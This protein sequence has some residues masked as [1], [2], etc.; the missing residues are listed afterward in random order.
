MKALKSTYLVALILLLPMAY[1][2]QKRWALI[3][4]AKEA[5]IKKDWYVA[6]QYYHQ[7]Y[8]KDSSNKIKFGYA[9]ACRLNYDTDVAI[10]IYGKL[11]AS[12]KGNKYPLAYYWMGQL[13]KNKQKYKEAKVWFAKFLKLELKDENHAY[14]NTKAKL[15]LEA[16]DLAERLI[17]SPLNLVSD[18]PAGPV[19]TK[20]SEYAAFEKDSSL[21]FSSLRGFDP[22]GEDTT[23]VYNKIY[24]VEIRNG[25]WQKAK[26]LD[27]SFNNPRTNNANTCFSADYKQIITSRCK[28]LNA[29][30]F[31][32]ELYISNFK[33]G[34]WQP[35]VK[36]E[37]PIN[38]DGASTT[39][40]NF[41]RVDGK[42]ALFFSS[43]RAGGEG[44]MDIWY[45]M[46]KSD[47]SFETPVNAGK[48]INTPDD[49][50]SPWYINESNQ[51]YFSSTYHK[52]LG[53]FDIF[54]SSLSN[55]QFSEP[56]NAGYPINSSYNDIYYSVSKTGNKIYL[57]SNRVGSMF[58]GK[59]NCCND[60]YSFTP[61]SISTPTKVCDGPPIVKK[62]TVVALKEQMKLLVPLTL[63]FHN[64]EP[65]PRTKLTSTTKN[66]QE[67][68]EDYK[69]LL[70]QYADKFAKGL[71]GE[72]RKTAINDINTFFADSLTAGFNH[73][74]RFIDMLQKVLQN[75][76]TVRIT[77]KGY[78]SPLASSDYNINLAKR[79]VSSLRN[80]FNEVHD[81]WFVRY[82]DNNTPGEGKIIFDEMDVGELSESK[83]SDDLKDKRNSV[84]SPSAASER[85]IQV[86]A[87]SFGN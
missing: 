5:V 36:M 23:R 24:K 4:G 2:A 21:Y 63:Y 44:G 53:G 82:I 76:E 18:H 81:G 1:K 17:A 56:E 11:A 35:S 66:Y 41:G 15:E 29:S 75:G 55:N 71:N 12:D 72:E 39:Q 32:C 59:L 37:A 45:A 3:A 64:D 86:I 25:K 22:K 10:K 34:K 33:D 60:I 69:E 13:L 58:E 40:A 52:G 83:A 61:K 62:D 8:K 7:L 54:K 20:A 70:G 38:Q 68:Y 48:K 27:T 78:C 30:E 65:N 16:C 6:Q 26:L 51:L 79:R 85:K 50:L 74:N 84:Y 49:E 42:P 28:A 46:Q 31:S 9:E 87:V 73:L 67:T 80:Y 47:G 19:N 43:N 57:S 14:Y 77:F